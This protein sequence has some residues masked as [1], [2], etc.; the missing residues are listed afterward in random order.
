MLELWSNT[1]FKQCNFQFDKVLD[2]IFTRNLF[3][4]QYD[5]WRNT[6]TELSPAFTQNKVSIE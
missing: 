6:R 1:T 5:D 4:T 3:A 2:P